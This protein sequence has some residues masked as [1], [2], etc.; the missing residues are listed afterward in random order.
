MSARDPIPLPKVHYANIRVK[1]SFE[2]IMHAQARSAKEIHLGQSSY[3]FS[4]LWQDPESRLLVNF[5][6]DN[7]PP[8]L[9]IFTKP[10]PTSTLSRN[11]FLYSIRPTMSSLPSRKPMTNA[12]Q[13]NAAGILLQ[14]LV[15]VV[16][17]SASW[18]EFQHRGVACQCQC[19]SR[20]YDR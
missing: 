9:S 8:G 7:P 19:P 17:V 14:K 6:F 16:R 3:W 11:I 18:F 10:R 1:E 13:M 2:R 15:P 4:D 5:D 12:K 20:C